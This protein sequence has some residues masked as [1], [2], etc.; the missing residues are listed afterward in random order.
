MA[1]QKFQF[2]LV[3]RGQ[4]PATDDMAQRFQETIAQ[5]RLADKLGFDSITKTS[6]Y[7]SH[8]FQMLQQVPLL[9]RFTA[10]VPNMRLNAGIVLLALPTPLDVA[11]NFAAIDVMSGGKL[12][13]GCALGYREVE[14]KAFGANMKDRV[15][16][17]EENLIA[18]KRL[19]TE[20][21]VSMKGGHFELDEASCLPRPLQKPHPPIWI[22]ANADPA[23][24]RAARLADAWY[25]NPHQ[26]VSTIQRQ[27]D[28]YRRAL[29][30]AGK[31]FPSEFPMRREVFVART[32]RDA[33][34]LC[35]PY[36]GAKYAAYANWGQE[37][38]M[39]DGDNSLSQAFDEL[40]GDRFI[41]GSPDEV[42]EQMLAIHRSTGVNHVVM[43]MEWAGM[44]QN[45]VFDTMQMMAEEV[46]PKVRSAL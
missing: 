29:D 28:L 17:F 11:E 22:G 46:I 10:E 42:A 8:P 31:P 24:E 20:E 33:M 43:G 3:V 23:I 25:I 14:F 7:S 39:P 37:K 38:A 36:L 35:A 27:M 30:K 18:V 12:I 13:F 2:G 6:H 26:Q 41:I 19:W 44:P 34:R 15:K 9:A 16:R 1:Q 45:L 5:A 4:Y 32:R 21:K 40:A